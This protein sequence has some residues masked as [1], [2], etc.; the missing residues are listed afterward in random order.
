MCQDGEREREGDREPPAGSWLLSEP[1]STEPDA[2]LDLVN[3]E[4]VT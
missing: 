1:V 3:H 4:I 2:R